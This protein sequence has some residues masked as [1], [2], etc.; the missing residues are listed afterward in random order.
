MTKLE[1]IRRS[2]TMVVGCG[3]LGARLADGLSEAGKNSIVVDRSP[4]A[5]RKLSTAYGGLTYIGD[6][7]DLEVLKTAGIETVQ[8]LIVV[9]DDDNTNIMIAQFAKAY[10]G[11]EKVITRLY[12]PERI[13]VYSAMDI[14][15]ICPLSLAES[16]IKSQMDFK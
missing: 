7:T 1:S 13:A 15:T 2:S 3:R 4:E 12:D 14:D 16:H 9:T 6:A 10:F 8:T 11:I 5:F